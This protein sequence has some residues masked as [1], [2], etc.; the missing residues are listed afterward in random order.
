MEKETS[1]N[2]IAFVLVSI[3]ILIISNYLPFIG[4]LF[5]S[6]VILNVIYHIAIFIKEN[7]EATLYFLG[8]LFMIFLAIVIS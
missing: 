1:I 6:L 7:H 5:L 2:I 3:I 8:F 4:I